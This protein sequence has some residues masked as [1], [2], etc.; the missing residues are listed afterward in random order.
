MIPNKKFFLAIDKIREHPM[1]EEPESQK[2]I[3]KSLCY[4]IYF[5][6]NKLSDY[7]MPFVQYS[8]DADIMLE[9]KKDDKMVLMIAFYGEKEYGYTYKVDGRFVAGKVETSATD[10][11]PYDL[12]EYLEQF[13]IQ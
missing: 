3:R 11:L 7:T 4:S 10:E 5:L 6:Q 13:K 8:A 1:F 2:T 12:K 9:W